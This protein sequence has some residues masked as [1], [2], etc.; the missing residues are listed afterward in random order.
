MITGDAAR[1]EVSA[2]RKD[3]EGVQ[4]PLAKGKSDKTVS[5]NIRREIH[6]GKPQAQAIA[7]AMRAAGRSKPGGGTRK[8]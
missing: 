4:M 3:R 5:E 2:M 8:R 6:A 1:E 7:I